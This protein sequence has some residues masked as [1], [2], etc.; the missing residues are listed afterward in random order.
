MKNIIIAAHKYLPH[1]D[2]DLVE[3]LVNTK[4]YSVMHIKHSFT[5]APDRKSYYDWFSGRKLFKSV[6]TADYSFLPEVL[7]YFKELIFTFYWTISSKQKWDV[8]IGMDGLMTFFGIILRNLGFCR[9]VIYWSIDFVPERRFGSALKNKIYNFVNKYSY[10]NSD[11]NWDLSPRMAGA[12]KKYMNLNSQ[13]KKSKIVP[14]GVWTNQ[15]KQVPYKNAEKN[16]LVF[17]GHLIPEKGVEMVLEN[18]YEI[19]KKVP[20]F[21][22]KIIGDGSHKKKLIKLAKEL[23]VYRYCNFLGQIKSS[24][25]MLKEIAKSAVAIAPYPDTSYARWAD[26]GKVKTYLAAGVPVLLTDVPWNAVEI[27]KEKC[28]LIVKNNGRDLVEKVVKIL[29]PKNNQKYRNNAINYSRN[30]DY[31]NIFS[32]IEMEKT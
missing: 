21:K 6:K 32:G 27:E 10:I 18:I 5:D 11:E 24:D 28:G 25:K 3:Y 20:E 31:K 16:T 13:R 14:F 17:M 23:K 8:F 2:E 12:R 9:K 19:V 30:F 7:I 29:N 22:F 15:I 26:P 1:P 4:R